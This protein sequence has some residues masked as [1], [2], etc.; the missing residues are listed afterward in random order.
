SINYYEKCI[1]VVKKGNVRMNA[2]KSLLLD[3]AVKAS[4][5]YN[6]GQAREE[7]AKIYKKKGNISEA[8]RNYRL[9][10]KNYE[11]ALENAKI[12]DLGTTRQQSYQDAIDRVT[13]QLNS[14]DGTRDKRSAY[15]HATQE[16]RKKNARADLLLY[17]KTHNGNMA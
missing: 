9:A 10:I 6:A 8:K 13:Q 4:S 12:G 1:A 16:M 15:N 14:L 5:Y 17:G 7:M 3:R 2:N 11:T